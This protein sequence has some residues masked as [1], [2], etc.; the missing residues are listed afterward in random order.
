MNGGRHNRRMHRVLLAS[1]A[2]VA[3][4]VAAGAL[5]S[6]W[7]AQRARATVVAGITNGFDSV[8]TVSQIS[9]DLA[10]ER[11]LVDADIAAADPVEMQR[12]A[13]RLGMVASD[14]EAAAGRYQSLVR[15]PD[16]N[17][18]W[19]RVRE[20]LDGLRAAIGDVL[21]LAAQNRD[22]EA[23]A[24]LAQIDDRFVRVDTDLAR[25]IDINRAGA[26]G[27]L[28]RADETER[29]ADLVSG[30]LA[31][32]AIA[33]VLV[34][35]G[36]VTR[37]V[38]R[39]EVQML[40]YAER[41]EE[42]NR[43][44]DAFAGRVAH[45]LRGPLTAMKMAFQRLLMETP[46]ANG[47][48]ETI[49]RSVTR[50]ERLITDLLALSQ[51]EAQSHGAVCNPAKAVAVVRDEQVGRAEETRATLRVD[52]EAA[53]VCAHEGLLI[54]ALSNLAENATKYVRPDVAP[55]IDISGRVRDGTYEL[56]VSDNGIGMSPEEV[57][58]AFTPFYRARRAPEAPGTG[59]GLSIVRRVAEASGGSV[60]LH[61]TLGL[62]STFIIR[63]PLAQGGGAR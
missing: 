35:G 38:G 39:R 63:L 60:S 43:E 48:G 3:A 44:L 15:F 37:L 33:L 24:G 29:S 40:R 51:V 14:L 49:R 10:R 4:I 12:T 6:L 62:G 42:Q 21:S 19:K 8:A 2:A 50:M 32:M 30:V 22:V 16:E 17:G 57:R 36:F 5:L 28:A 45:D 13:T 18:V 52:V 55:E 9:R 31:A 27:L 53:T 7:Q 25:L 58:Q 41:L 20:D 26:L 34:V 1:F 47:R 61:S 11:L 46:S 54:E 59:L 23:R 56:S